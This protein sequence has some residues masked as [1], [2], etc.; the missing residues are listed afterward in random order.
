MESIDSDFE[1]TDLGTGSVEVALGQT[2]VP[3][4]TEA[5]RAPSQA[6]TPTSPA[7]PTSSTTSAHSQCDG[8]RDLVQ[9]LQPL[10][11]SLAA[12]EAQR[13]ASDARADALA[14]KLDAIA[15]RLD[16]GS[17]ASLT[18]HALQVVGYAHT[19]T[20]NARLDAIVERL[21]STTLGAMRVGQLAQVA[22]LGERLELLTKTVSSDWASFQA[23]Q[24]QVLRVS[25]AVDSLETK[26]DTVMT[27]M[28]DNTVHTQLAD[29]AVDLGEAKKNTTAMRFQ[30]EPPSTTDQG[31][32][33][34]N[35]NRSPKPSGFWIPV[36]PPLL[37]CC[38][39]EPPCRDDPL[40]GTDATAS[41]D[42]G[43]LPPGRPPVS[44]PLSAPPTL[45]PAGASV[46][47]LG[48]SPPA[49][50]SLPASHERM[51]EDKF[52]ALKDN[53]WPCD[54]REPATAYLARTRSMTRR[55]REQDLK[56]TIRWF[57][58]PTAAH[59]RVETH[60]TSATTCGTSGN[61]AE[62]TGAKD[63]N[64][65]GKVGG[66]K[67]LPHW[68]A[69]A[70][71]AILFNSRPQAPANSGMG[72]PTAPTVSAS[73]SLPAVDSQPVDTVPPPAAPDNSSSHPEN[74]AWNAQDPRDLD[75]VP[76]STAA[77]GPSPA[78]FADTDAYETAPTE[79]FLFGGPDS[80][81]AAAA[82]KAEFADDNDLALQAAIL[83]SHEAGRGTAT[84]ESED[85]DEE[86]M[87]LDA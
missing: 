26:I 53:H 69:K 44:F 34:D 33:G 84:G 52:A 16:K 25:S 57:G 20:V 86:Q 38:S 82:A 29:L 75:D 43:N 28:K 55:R 18:D 22:Q 3:V 54:Y 17:E 32:Q 66:S 11:A 49:D 56:D 14:A 81:L 39:T 35:V 30:P 9:S 62:S 58:Q 83:L 68:Y 8:C 5:A 23:A 12:S 65:K 60:D 63:S 50:T 40:L 4:H 48:P 41:S 10:I 73:A 76:A 77:P 7:A 51:D 37:T 71:E 19:E 45:S 2:L 78:V 59:R 47:P 67:G 72:A 31:G 79:G 46:F 15:D 42:G 13:A 70:E 27:W 85:V 80:A 74:D 21:E 87:E 24:A 64:D 6:A 36:T 61:I 1:W